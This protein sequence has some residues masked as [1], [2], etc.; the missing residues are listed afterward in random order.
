MEKE[1]FY[2]DGL[3][4]ECQRCSFCCGHSPGYSIAYFDEIYDIYCTEFDDEILADYKAMYEDF[5]RQ[6]SANFELKKDN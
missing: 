3:H 1:P 6:K 5:A 4:F 2:K